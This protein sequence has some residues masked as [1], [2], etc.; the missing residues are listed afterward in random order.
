MIGIL[1]RVGKIEAHAR[2]A[3]EDLNDVLTFFV[4]LGIL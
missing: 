2:E 4:D 3:F 1:F